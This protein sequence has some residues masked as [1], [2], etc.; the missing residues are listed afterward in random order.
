MMRLFDEPALR[1]QLRALGLA[2]V[3]ATGWGAAARALA[4]QLELPL[5]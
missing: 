2:R 3:A 1:E 4:T 5:A